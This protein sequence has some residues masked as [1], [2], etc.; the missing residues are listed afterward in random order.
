MENLKFL[1]NKRRG[2]FEIRQ[3]ILIF[4]IELFKM[5]SQHLKSSVLLTQSIYKVA[6]YLSFLLLA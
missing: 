3:Q 5:S 6:V 2:I 1:L 4:E